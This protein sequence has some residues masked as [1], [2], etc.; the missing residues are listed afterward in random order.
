MIC[1]GIIKGQ[2]EDF[3]TL[4]FLKIKLPSPKPFPIL[5]LNLK[6]APQNNGF[7]RPTTELSLAFETE[8]L[9]NGLPSYYAGWQ[10]LWKTGK[11]TGAQCWESTDLEMHPKGGRFNCPWK[12]K[13]SKLLSH[14]IAW[15]PRWTSDYWSD[16][17]WNISTIKKVILG[18]PI[19]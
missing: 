6:T 2:A 16:D 5:G 17:I 1:S 11:L 7:A 9:T 4:L 3:W 18:Q 8:S 10:A 12:V 19:D 14:L 15:L 13:M